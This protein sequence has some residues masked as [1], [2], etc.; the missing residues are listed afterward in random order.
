MGYSKPTPRRPPANTVFTMS[1][2]CRPCGGK[3]SFQ[4]KDGAN[5]NLS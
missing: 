4:T 5:L 3:V 1:E 2:P